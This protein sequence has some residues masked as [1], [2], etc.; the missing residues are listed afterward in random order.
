MKD[1]SNVNIS[2][3]KF[4]NNFA[5]I[6]NGADGGALR[7]DDSS[8]HISSSIFTDNYASGDG[9][10]LIFNNTTA[11]VTNSCLSNN[12]AGGLG[13]GIYIISNS[14][15]TLT[16]SNVCSNAP[17]QIQGNYDGLDN[18]VSFECAVKCQDYLPECPDIN[19]DG[20]VGAT[21]ILNVLAD[22]GLSD[23]PADVTQDGIVD[24][25]DI[26]LVVSNWGPCN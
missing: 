6:T 22:W 18:T 13:G 16:S 21:D 25:S 12:T 20:N 24:I 8:V 9:G 19:G 15:A 10:G 23:T 3:C 17:N 11:A 26:L 4:Y 5:S 1:A 7:C 2:A 14:N